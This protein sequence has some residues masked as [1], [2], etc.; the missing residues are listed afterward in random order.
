MLKETMTAIVPAKLKVAIAKN[1]FKSSPEVFQTHTTCSTL[2]TYPGIEAFPTQMVRNHATT[3]KREAAAK[4]W[5]NE[6]QN[7]LSTLDDIEKIYKHWP[8]VAPIALN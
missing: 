1:R 5:G 8:P 7:L 3:M 4:K 6:T 2:S